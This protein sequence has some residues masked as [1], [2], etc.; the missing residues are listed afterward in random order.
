MPRRKCGHFWRLLQRLFGLES[1]DH[2]HDVPDDIRNASHALANETMKL[3][4]TLADRDK[5]D[6]ALRW[7]VD[8]MQQKLE[9]RGN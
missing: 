6:D 7:L 1:R 4:S 2:R 9:H 8:A 5:R 3:R